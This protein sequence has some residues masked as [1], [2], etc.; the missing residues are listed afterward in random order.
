MIPFWVYSPIH[1][2]DI[3]RN[4]PIV[5]FTCSN[6]QRITCPESFLGF[7]TGFTICNLAFSC[8]VLVA[9]RKLNSSSSRY[10]LAIQGFFQSSFRMPFAHLLFGLIRQF[11]ATDRFFQSSFR[12][13]FAHFLFGLIGQF[14]ATDRFFQGAFWMPFAH[15]LFGLIRQFATADRFLQISSGMSLPKLLFRIKSSFPIDNPAF[16]CKFSVAACKL[17]ASSCRY[18]PAMDR[19]FQSPLGMPFPDCLFRLKR[20][21]A[22]INFFVQIG[23]RIPKPETRFGKHVNF[24]VRDFIINNAVKMP[25]SIFGLYTTLKLAFPDAIIKVQLIQEKPNKNP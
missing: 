20:Q 14:A 18:F 6:G 22:L 2:I 3:V 12:M 7:V 19:F 16:G 5:Q 10:F 23:Q 24:H 1:F 25:F 8:K 9:A 17:N 11:A 21:F 13:P 15:F 4:M